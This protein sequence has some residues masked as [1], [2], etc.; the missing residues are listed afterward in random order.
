MWR[1]AACLPIASNW[2]VVMNQSEF[3]AD[4]RREGY[5]VFFGG[6][7]AGMTNDAHAHDF[8][9]RVMY[10]AA[11]SPSPGTARR[12]RSGPVIVAWSRPGKCMPN[13]WV[14]R[15]SRISPDIARSEVG[16]VFAPE[17]RASN[18]GLSPPGR[19][20][21]RPVA[22]S[23]WP[24]VLWSWRVVRSSWRVVRS[25][26]RVVRSSWPGLT[27]PPA[28]TRSKPARRTPLHGSARIDPTTIQLGDTINA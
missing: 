13:T 9:A 5:P 16:G 3:E 24:V 15:V 11:R 8:D 19:P 18:R 27:G 28:S 17:A 4:P 1:A 20:S 2:K 22:L 6:L 14:R 25:S 12:K 23:S 10:S 21:S 26:R 7:K